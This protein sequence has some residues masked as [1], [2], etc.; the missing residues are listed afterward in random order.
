MIQRI[1][2][3]I[4][5]QATDALLEIG[6]GTGALTQSLVPTVQH[7]MAVEVDHA[8]IA[9]LQQQFASYKHFTLMEGDMLT[10]PLDTDPWVQTHSPIRIVGN[11]PYHISTPL[12]F[13]LLEA[14]IAIKDMHFML[15]KEVVDRMAAAPGSKTYG[16][17]SVMCQYHCA[18]YPLF[19][20]DKA[21]FDPIPQVQSKILRCIPHP[22]LSFKAHDYSQFAQLVREA[23][24][25]RRKTLKNTLKAWHTA[26]SLENLGIDPQARP[27][28]LSVEQYVAL[29]NAISMP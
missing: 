28:T 21:A 8:L 4:A 6:P 3:A 7:F 18:V 19:T 2:Q 12:M 29:S 23:F 24:Q 11:L 10:F 9:P 27:E 16:R 22:T 26:H 5:P 1:V 17:L 13:H 15:Q 25:H 14:Q 20:V